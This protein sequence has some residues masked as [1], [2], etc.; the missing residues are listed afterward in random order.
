[1]LL[2]ACWWRGDILLHLQ[3][4]EHPSPEENYPAPN[5]HSPLVVKPCFGDKGSKNRVEASLSSPVGCCLQRSE[6]V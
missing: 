5:I 3:V 2:A 6:E 4:A 1:M